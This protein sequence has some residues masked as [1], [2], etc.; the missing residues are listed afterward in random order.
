[1]PS[2]LYDQAKSLGTINGYVFGG[3]DDGCPFWSKKLPNGK[4][5]EMILLPED[6][7]LK[8][9]TYMAEHEL[10]RM[11]EWVKKYQAKYRKQQRKAMS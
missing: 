4:Y 7:E 9:F 10:T 5:A 8:N 11:P 3:I 2:T 6:L 1:M